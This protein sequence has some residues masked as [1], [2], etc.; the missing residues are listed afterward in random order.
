MTCRAVLAAAA[1]SLASPGLGACGE[2]SPPPVCG[3]TRARAVSPHAQCGDALDFTPINQYQGAIASIQDREDAVALLDGDCTGTLIAAAAGPVVLTAG[4]CVALGDQVLVAFNI[5]DN[6]D[7]DMLVTGGTA[8]EQSDEPD[9][10]LVKLDRIPRA[11]P[12]ALTTR[13]SALLAVIQHPR[14]APKAI[15]EGELAG[16]CNRQ[17]YYS[18]LD[19]LVGS[20]G[21]GVLNDTGY[22]LGVHTDGDCGKTGGTNRGWT[23]EAI[24]AASA[25][26]E[27]ADLADR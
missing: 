20:S 27:D 15:A 25:Y 8:I 22:L 10:A 11:A 5:E 1:L 19:T 12:T 24:V 26:L 9:Y 7:G 4:H 18:D 23:A 16:A 3:A 6:P 21:A 17:L 13:Q 2:S 14:G